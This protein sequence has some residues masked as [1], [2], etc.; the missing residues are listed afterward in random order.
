MKQR[1]IHLVPIQKTKEAR[2]ACR[3][4]EKLL[5]HIFGEETELAIRRNAEKNLAYE[6]GKAFGTGW[7]RNFDG[8]DVAALCRGKK[9]R[10][11]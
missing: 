4:L 7:R 8:L 6:I 9:R 2:E 1:L 3:C 11:A 10:P 5:N